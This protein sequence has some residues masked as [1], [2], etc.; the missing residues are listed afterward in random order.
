MKNELMRR[1]EPPV[2]VARH[3]RPLIPHIPAEPTPPGG[4]HPF[5]P[6]VPIRQ[7]LA[8][9]MDETQV[10][11]DLRLSLGRQDRKDAAHER[12]PVLRAGLVVALLCVRWRRE[13]DVGFLAAHQ[14]RNIG[15][16]CRVSAEQAVA[17]FG[18]GIELMPAMLAGASDRHRL[19]AR[20]SGVLL[21]H[22]GHITF[23]PSSHRSPVCDTVQ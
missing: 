10:H 22:F 17:T 5:D 16:A 19:I 11:Q 14:P 9:V 20:S 7:P 6:A 8:V 4:A 3:A 21:R 12:I 13:A 23:A 2:P 18:L 1:G 15:G